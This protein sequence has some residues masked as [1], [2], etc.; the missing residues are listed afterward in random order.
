MTFIT[1]TTDETGEE[2]RRARQR[3]GRR[4]LWLRTH[5]VAGVG[6]VDL[7]QVAD[8]RVEDVHLLHQAGEGRLGGLTHLLIHALHLVEVQRRVI[9]QR[10]DGGQL[11]QRVVLVAPH[12]LAVLEPEHTEW[13]GDARDGRS[14]L[15]PPPGFSSQVLTLLLQVRRWNR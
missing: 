1:T 7:G 10:T 5:R 8:V 2:G 3:G 11:H 14:G 13:D 12:W 15:F 6:P 4:S 9:A